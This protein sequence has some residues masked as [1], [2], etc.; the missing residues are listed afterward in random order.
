M[1]ERIEHFRPELQLQLFV[2]RE[3][4]EHAEV[5]EHAAPWTEE[6]TAAGIAVGIRGFCHKAGSVKPLGRGR[7][8]ES[9]VAHL[10]R[11]P[12]DSSLTVGIYQPVV[13]YRQGITALV[14]DG[15]AAGL[16]AANYGVSD[17]AVVEEPS[18]PAH[19]QVEDEVDLRFGGDVV[20]RSSV[21]VPHEFIWNTRTQVL[22]PR[23]IE[24]EGV[25]LG[26]LSEYQ[27]EGI[28]P[29]GIVGRIPKEVRR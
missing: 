5:G 4:L 8:A 18:S 2:Q 7:I 24:L 25:V 11:T 10:I 12:S 29:V 6:V 23:V 27:F 20:P 17:P 15:E 14:Q 22:R 19:R 13:S 1:V 28:V 16:P 21:D 3:V 26:T 9:R